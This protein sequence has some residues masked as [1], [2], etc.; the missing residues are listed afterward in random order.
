MSSTSILINI[1]LVEKVVVHSLIYQRCTSKPKKGLNCQEWILRLK[2]DK[3][4]NDSTD[5]LA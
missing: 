5:I 1:F 4:L 2:S 3:L